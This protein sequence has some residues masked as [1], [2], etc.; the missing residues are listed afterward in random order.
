[1]AHQERRRIRRPEGG[2]EIAKQV[3]EGELVLA[4]SVIESDGLEPRRGGPGDSAA[5][6]ARLQVRRQ[7]QAL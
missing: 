3:D 7:P 5:A 6:R 1:M 2:I 4:D